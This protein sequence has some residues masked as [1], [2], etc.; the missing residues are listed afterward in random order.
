MVNGG[1]E[2]FGE[3]ASRLREAVVLKNTGYFLTESLLF[4]SIP[5]WQGWKKFES[6]SEE[7]VDHVARW[8]VFFPPGNESWWVF[9]RITWPSITD[10]LLGFVYPD[11]DRILEQIVLHRRLALIDLPLM[12]GQPH[13]L[14]KGVMVDDIPIDL[15]EGIAI[16]SPNKEFLTH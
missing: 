7:T 16:G 12:G 14:S 5:D 15:L 13:P 4:I 3:L 9:L 2:S 8:E 6:A 11:D 10:I 1:N